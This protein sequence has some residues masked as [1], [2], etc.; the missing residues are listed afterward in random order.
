MKN[1]LLPDQYNF[2]YLFLGLFLAI[3]R[4]AT[5]G[6]SNWPRSSGVD[7]MLDQVRVR[8]RSPL[9]NYQLSCGPGSNTDNLIAIDC[10]KAPKPIQT[11]VGN[12]DHTRSY[13]QQQNRGIENQNLLTVKRISSFH[14]NRKLS[15]SLWNARSINNK[16]A[17]VCSSIVE[18]DTDIFAVT[19][20][21]IGEHRQCAVS[22]FKASLS[23]YNVYQ[24]PA[25]NR[26][27]GGVALIIRSDYK[28]KKMNSGLFKSFEHVDLTVTVNDV[29]TPHRT[30]LP[31][32]PSRTNGCKT[33]DFLVEFASFLEVLVIAPGRLIILGDFNIHV[34]N[35]TNGDALKFHDLLCSMNLV[36][37]VRGSTHAT[38]HTLDAGVLGRGFSFRCVRVVLLYV[39]ECL[40]GE[41]VGRFVSAG[42][43]A[44]VFLAR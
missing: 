18:N 7:C 41:G 23:G 30:Y 32:P 9:H 19:E 40:S 35:A 10:T 34:D 44:Y 33:A 8:P 24:R 38:G 15:F 13:Q 20:T 14:R 39:F 22:E 5:R 36:E 25:Q 42:R 12:R 28:V 4:E 27:G 6:L 17:A 21:W 37:L 31:A 11:V 3:Y 1:L 29:T 2:F 16:I 43:R 26:K